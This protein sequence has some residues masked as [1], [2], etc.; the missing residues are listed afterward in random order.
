[1]IEIIDVD[2]AAD[3]LLRGKVVALATDTV[4]GVAASL[5]HPDAVQSLFA[6]KE[7]PDSKPLPVLAHSVEQIEAYGVMWPLLAR[8]LA[9]KFWPGALT[10]V[11]AVP[12]RIARTVGSTTMS[13]GFRVP[14]DAQ[15]L[16]VLKRCGA[17]CVTSANIHGEP[18]C[19]S[20]SQVQSAFRDRDEL[21]GVVDG[22]ERHGEVSTV[23][24]VHD[25]Q[26]RI[27]RH[28]A[29]GEDEIAAVLDRETPGS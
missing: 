12:E 2:T 6:L 19:E 3:L 22:G 21:A 17:L 5:A 25:D 14:D 16:A 26:W 1:M 24:E 28:G 7:R 8:R 13:A 29:I 18:P 20:A 15:L 27:V 10:I 11:V 9:R 4:Y 23:V